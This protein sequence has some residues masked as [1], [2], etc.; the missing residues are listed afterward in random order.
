MVKTGAFYS[1][2]EAMKKAGLYKENTD[3]GLSEIK[4]NDS[5]LTPVES[6]RFLK[7]ILLETAD[8]EFVEQDWSAN[9]KKYWPQWKQN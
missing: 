1:N 2:L 4:K 3:G 9:D 7:Y 8:E 5:F 6:A